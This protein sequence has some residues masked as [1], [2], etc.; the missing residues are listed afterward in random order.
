V[1]DSNLSNTA[2]V[3]ALSCDRVFGPTLSVLVQSVSAC[4]I[5]FPAVVVCRHGG[6]SGRLADQRLQLLQR[7]LLPVAAVVADVGNGSGVAA[8]V[9]VK[10]RCRTQCTAGKWWR[11]AANKKPEV[12]R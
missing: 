8:L 9:F 10:L 2:A 6:T 11:T 7:L 4:R 12:D 1:L 3:V 5:R